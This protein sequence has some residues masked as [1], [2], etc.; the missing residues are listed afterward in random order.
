MSLVAFGAVLMKLIDSIISQNK[1]KY[2]VIIKNL[3][4]LI[5]KDPNFLEL[6]AKRK[7]GWIQLAF[8]E[9]LDVN[10]ENAIARSMDLTYKFIVSN[11][12]ISNELK[13]EEI[14]TI[15]ILLLGLLLAQTYFPVDQISRSS[16]EFRTNL[17]NIIKNSKKSKFFKHLFKKNLMK[18]IIKQMYQYYTTN[19][20]Y[21][22]DIDML[23]DMQKFGWYLFTSY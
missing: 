14:Q 21:S 20:N 15:M 2:D 11:D 18:E 4:E 5:K 23:S 8:G 19:E 6:G 7:L 16:M 12:E 10:K 13:P 22:L 3:K 17:E 9:S 1:S